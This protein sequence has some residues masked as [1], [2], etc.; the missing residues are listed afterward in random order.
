MRRPGR[1]GQPSRPGAPAAEG[2]P[3]KGPEV[4]LR[5]PPAPASRAG[6]DALKG[7]G[8]PPGIPWAAGKA[9]AGKSGAAVLPAW[10]CRVLPGAPCAFTSGAFWSR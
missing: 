1:E 8:K 4:L 2:T 6:Q 3:A 10:R 5:E 9:A 7:N